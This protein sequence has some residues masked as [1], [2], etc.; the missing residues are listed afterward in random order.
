MLFDCVR[1]M[2]T[3]IRTLHYY[4]Q[5]I[6]YNIATAIRPYTLPHGMRDRARCTP[7]SIHFRDCHRQQLSPIVGQINSL[8]YVGVQCIYMHNICIYVLCHIRCVRVCM[9]MRVCVLVY[10]SNN[11]VITSIR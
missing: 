3:T 8:Y 6:L 1:I 5:Y 2:I 9:Y 7:N 4:I 11:V 10:I